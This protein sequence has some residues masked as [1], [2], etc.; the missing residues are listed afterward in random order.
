MKLKIIQAGFESYSGQL[1]N[2]AFKD[3]VSLHDVNEIE[4]A[5]VRA[6]MVTEVI[7]GEASEQGDQS[8]ADQDADQNAGQD[9]AAKAAEAE[10]LAAEA[11]R[12]R[13]EADA[14]EALALN[15][16]L[17]AEEA[18]SEEGAAP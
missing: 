18:A 16:A 15:A 13:A 10:C 14:A 1:G 2:V 3:G 5:F 8:E 17:A 9:A 7:E 11:D 12:E 4:S 6:L